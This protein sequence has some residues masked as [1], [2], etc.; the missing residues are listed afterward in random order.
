[1]APGALTS[2]NGESDDPKNQEDECS[3]PQEMDGES[4]TK[5]D[6]HQQQREYEQHERRLLFRRFPKP[7][8]IRGRF[9]EET[10]T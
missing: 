8:V 9:E 10:P 5:D 1:V 2:A 4:G 7:S 3:D 6:Q